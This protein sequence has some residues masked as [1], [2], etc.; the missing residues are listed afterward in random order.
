MDSLQSK[1]RNQS[2]GVGESRDQAHAEAQRKLFVGIKYGK[3]GVNVAM[4]I[5]VK[6][7]G[8][9]IFVEAIDCQ[10]VRNGNGWILDFVSRAD[11]G[12]IV[13][14]GASGQNLLASEMK[15]QKIKPS[16]ILPTVKEII[17][18]NA[19]FE[20]GIYQESI[21]HKDQPSLEQ[22]VTN[23]EK[24]PIGSTGGFGYKSQFDDY[25]VALMD[26]IILA[27]WACGEQAAEKQRIRY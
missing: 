6:T 24:R 9:K 22:V 25:D 14:D 1:I 2:G 16:P 11:V 5:A 18:A 23:S 27:H 3:D 13:I 20:Q 10:S 26:S 8:G 12:Q 4:S 17:T 19:S 21:A 7:A 15:E